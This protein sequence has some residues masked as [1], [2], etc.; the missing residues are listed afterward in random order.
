MFPIELMG[1]LWHTTSLER[2]NRILEFGA[3]SPAPDIPD[4]ERCCTRGGS[5]TYPYVRHIGGVSLFDFE[6][7][8]PEIYSEKYPASSWSFFVPQC[9]KYDQTVWIEI[10][11]EQAEKKSNKRR[12]LVE[13]MEKRW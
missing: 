1:G 8:N 9:E 6:D 10:N 5:A 2:F 7:F 3:I 11:R 12:G 13:Q 4:S